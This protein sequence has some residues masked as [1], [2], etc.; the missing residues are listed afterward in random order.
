M[1]KSN[2]PIICING[3]RSINYINLDLFIDPNHVGCVVSGGA[4]GVDTL[5]E[6]WAKRNHIEFIAYLPQWK[7]FGK[8]AGI[9]RNH[10]MIEFCD[11]L[12]SFWD[13][14][15][16]GTL[17]TIIYA[18]KLGVPAYVHLINNLD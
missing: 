9:I 4:N 13:G 8:K 1:P 14:K 7:K 10:E 16:K 3:S 18:K 11:V 6:H 17:D 2:K 5:A 12:I 15:S